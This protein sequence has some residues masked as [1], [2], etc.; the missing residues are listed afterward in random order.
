MEKQIILTQ[1]GSHSI[2]SDEFG[3]SYHSRYGAIQESRH[4]YIERGLYSRVL[5]QKKMS[6]LEIGFG[7]GLNALLTL[8][9]AEKRELQV[10]YEAVEAYPVTEEQAVLLNYPTQLG[11]PDLSAPFLAL[12]T[13]PW[14]E[15]QQITPAFEFKKV[16]IHFEDLSYEPVFDLIYFDAFAPNAQPHLWELPVLSTMYAALKEEGVLVT[17]CAKGS[18]KRTLKSLGFKVES[19]PGPPGKR[20]MTRCIKPREKGEAD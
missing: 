15:T 20:E 2:Y 12:H 10:Y 6:I 14:N 18:V 7:T 13:L 8:L 19:L 16:N 9:E 11:R 3:V 4:V 17:Y 1:D 5:T